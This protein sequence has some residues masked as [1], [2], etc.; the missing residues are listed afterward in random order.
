M[1]IQFAD[2]SI[3]I[4]LFDSPLRYDLELSYKHLQHV[5][6]PPDVT[7][8]LGKMDLQSKIANLEKCAK[9]L[10]ISIDRTRCVN[11]DQQ[12][13]NMLHTIYEKNYDGSPT[14]LNFHDAIHT[15]ESG[16][17]T[18]V[19]RLRYNDLAGPLTKK[20]HREWIHAGVTQIQAGDVFCSWGELGKTPYRYWRDG[21]PDDLDRI[22][23]LVKPWLDF[24]P[25]IHIALKDIDFL[26]PCNIP[27]FLQWWQSYQ[28]AWC[29][30]WNLD[31]WHP[32]E[33]FFVIPVGR[34]DD[35]EALKHYWDLNVRP[36][37]VCLDTEMSTEVLHFNIEIKASYKT[38]C[39][40]VEISIDDTVIEKTKLSHG[41]NIIDFDLAIAHSDHVLKIV[42]SGATD[43]DPTQKVEIK[44][45]KC[46]N[47]DLEQMIL[48]AS[49]YQPNYPEIW[50]QQQRQQGVELL[51]SVPYETVLAHDGSWYL[52]F[53][54]PFYP[55]YLAVSRAPFQ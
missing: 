16:Y 6:I 29:H 40:F 36:D 13:F 55:N 43:L 17:S 3:G 14:W 48:K 25:D 26:K 2:H 1:R 11:L 49:H 45:I 35:F 44:Q 32:L 19:L 42:R 7:G 21:E 27:Q 20:M 23:E 53:S 37:R 54:S 4:R 51:E 8:R 15:C 22:L 34:I 9:V 46:D 5:D 28:S 10:D 39:P 52:N 33:Q 24:R 12:Y 41:R 47:L 18:D 31:D 30:H 38:H 50:A